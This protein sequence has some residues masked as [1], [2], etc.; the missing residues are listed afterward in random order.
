M[1]VNLAESLKTGHT[2]TSAKVL[3]PPPFHSGVRTK[4]LAMCVCYTVIHPCT[5]QIEIYDSIKKCLVDERPGE[6]ADCV[7]WARLQF[8]ENYHNTIQQL[9]YN[10]PEDQAS[11]TCCLCFY[12][13][14]VQTFRFQKQ[15]QTL[16]CS[17]LST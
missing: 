10:F 13:S 4:V 16:L 17:V 6:F 2:C 15:P 7:R 8:Q 3:C 11:W 14:R 9:L 5:T 1:V 12:P